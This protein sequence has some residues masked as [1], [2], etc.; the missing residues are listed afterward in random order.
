MHPNIMAAR[1]ELATSL[2]VSMIWAPNVD[3]RALYPLSYAMYAHLG[4]YMTMTP[5]RQAANRG[6]LVA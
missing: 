4:G 3:N 1:F 2:P 6:V 5:Y